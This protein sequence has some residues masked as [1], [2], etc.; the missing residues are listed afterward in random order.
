MKNSP[1]VP[2]TS[3]MEAEVLPFPEFFNLWMEK[4]NL[5]PAQAAK[6]VRC[7]VSTAYEW[8]NGEGCPRERSVAIYAPRFGMT[9]AALR[10]IIHRHREATKPTA[11]KLTGIRRAKARV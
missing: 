5:N 6:L 2:R 11:A 4:K 8:A 10:A 1:K 3:R 9:R 7:A